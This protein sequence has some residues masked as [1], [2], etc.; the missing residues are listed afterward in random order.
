M[1]RWIFFGLVAFAVP[2]WGQA[3]Q[4]GELALAQ[5]NWTH[6]VVTQKGGRKTTFARDDV[7]KVEYV[8]QGRP[9]GQG[10]GSFDGRWNSIDEHNGKAPGRMN[11]QQKGDKVSGTFE[12]RG[13]GGLIEGIV[14]NG[15]LRGTWHNSAGQSGP[16]ELILSA[17]G[18]SYSGFYLFNG[19]K[20]PWVGT[21]AR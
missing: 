4:G 15:V 1:C 13:G 21:R 8:T 12:Q 10:G 5:S 16:V 17:D 3:T 11:F 6:V 7:V 14:R 19:Q 18:S 20:Y 2:A 9:V